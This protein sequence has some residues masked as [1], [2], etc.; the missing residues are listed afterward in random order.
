MPF[1]RGPY[2]HPISK[3]VLAGVVV[4]STNDSA[5]PQ[6]VLQDHPY[7]RWGSSTSVV[8]IDT[9]VLDRQ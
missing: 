1:P 6:E 4:F 9:A 3:V 8:K 2:A 7:T 5:L